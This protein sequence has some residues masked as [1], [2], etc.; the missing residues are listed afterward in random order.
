MLRKHLFNKQSIAPFLITAVVAVLFFQISVVTDV[1]VRFT[2]TFFK[3]G[4]FSLII[5]LCSV[6]RN[7]GLFKGLSYIGYRKYKRDVRKQN[8]NNTSDD[9][10]KEDNFEQ[11]IAKKYAVKWIGV[12]YFVLT[13]V[14]ALLFIVFLLISG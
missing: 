13:G 10:V 11:F 1:H 14:Y 12:P 5:G 3:A 9:D 7:G 6:V 2:E 8:E 4:L